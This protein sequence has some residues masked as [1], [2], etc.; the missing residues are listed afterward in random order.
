[1]VRKRDPSTKLAVNP[2][3]RS[4]RGAKLEAGL[5]RLEADVILLVDH[6]AQSVRQIHRRPRAQ[7]MLR[8]EPRQL[9]AHEVPLEQQRPVAGPQLVDAD[10]EAIVQPRQYLQGFAELDEHAEPLAVARTAGEGVAVHVPR[11]SH[12]RREHDVRMRPGG[13]QPPDSAVGK[14]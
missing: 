1:V 12:A 2:V 13:I 3:E 14:Q 8:L 6:D 11:E 7:R 4:E 5:Q 10:E 9:L